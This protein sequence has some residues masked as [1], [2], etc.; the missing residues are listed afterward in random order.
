M[1]KPRSQPTRNKQRTPSQKHLRMEVLEH[2]LLLA[3]DTYLVN[4]QNDEATTPIRYERD[5]GDVFGA[6]GNGLSYGWSADHTDRAIERSADADQRLDTIISIEA[7]EDWEFALPNGNYEVTVGV[8]DPANNDGVHT[9]NVEGVSF[10][11]AEPDTSV[12]LTSTAQVTVSDGRLTLDVGAAANLATRINYIQI[13]GVPSGPNASPATPIVTEPAVDGQVVNPTDPHMEAVGFSDGDGDLHKSTDWEIWTVGPGA[14]PVW[15]T[16]GIEGVERLHTHLGDGIFLNALA[17]ET[18]LASNT[19]YEVRARFRDDAG[20]VSGYGTRLFQTGAASSV[21]PMEIE[22]IAS[23]PTP[24]WETTTGTPVEL[25]A[26][27]AI[28]SPGDAILAIDTDFGD[29]NYPFNETPQDG[30]DGNVGTKYLNFG[31]ANSGFIV[32]PSAGASVVTSFQ[33]TT[34]NDAEERDP[35]SWELYGTNDTVTSGDNSTGSAENWTL[36]DAGA[37]SLPSTRNTAGPVVDVSN[38]TSYTSYR[39]IF[40]GI[41]NAGAADS[42]QI[43]EAQFF[44]EVSGLTG[45]L[46]PGSDII[47]IDTSFGQ[48]NYPGNESP[49]NAIDGT[50]DKYLNFGEVNSGFIVTPSAAATVVESFQIT[51]ANDSEERD[52]TSWQLFGTNDPITSEDNSTGSAENWTLIDSGNV[53]LP[54]ARN[55]LGPVVPVNN[56]TAYQSYRM[57]FTGVKNAAAANSMQIAEIEFFGDN[58]LPPSSPSLRIESETGELLLA[59]DGDEAAGN[60]LTNPP[61]LSSHVDVRVVIT[62]GSGGLGLGNTD[63]TFTDD[64]GQERTIFLPEISLGAGETAYFWVSLDGSTYVGQAGQT[65]ADF[66]F[67]ARPAN[68]DVPFIAMQP[69]YVVEEVSSDYRLPVNIAFVP[70]PGPNPDDPLYYITELYGSIQ[71]VTRDGTKHEFATGL[72][73]YNPQGPISGSGEQGLTGIAVQRDE[74]NLDIYHL[75]VGMLWDN[76]SPP[77]GASHY[78]KVERLDSVAGGLSL[79]TRTVLLN[80]QPETQGQSH[81]ISNITIGPD[82]KLYVHNGDGFDAST[83]LDL[84]QY[85]GKILRMNLDGT[86]PTDN[87]FYDAG[88]GIN[89]RDYIYAYGVRNPFGGAWRASDGKHYAVENGPSVDRM[90]QIN[91][92]VN[93]GWNGSN[94]SMFI[95]AIYNWNPSHAPVNI[96]FVQPETFDGSLFPAEMQDMAFVSESGP[97]YAQGAQAQGKR[98]VGFELDANGDVVGGPTTLV[99]YVGLGRS[100]VVGLAAG[101]DGLYFT[102]LYEESGA[103]GPTASGARVFRVRYVGGTTGDFDI[104]GDVD[105]ADLTRWQ[106]GYGTTT[107]ATVANGDTD[108]DNDVDGS[109]FLAWQRNYTGTPVPSA[110]SAVAAVAT[111]SAPVST[112]S[113]P[114]ET[115]RSVVASTASSSVIEGLGWISVPDATISANE[116]TSETTDQRSNEYVARRARYQA[117]DNYEGQVRGSKAVEIVA[118]QQRFRSDTDSSTLDSPVGS[119]SLDEAFDRWFAG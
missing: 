82:G 1:S 52:P 111:Q 96:T 70:D 30:I 35:T 25:P 86:A 80:M 81:Q 58:G 17:G 45:L 65:E 72:L 115:E 93:Y 51:T 23:S 92:G 99:E 74:N 21:F 42:M 11:N 101:P 4:F 20:A 8:G 63:I 33:I 89:S 10:W 40:T 15:Q 61:E 50:L 29:S 7:G 114:A 102:E 16:L 112:A 59:I 55:T 95:N 37:I 108:Q 87:P 110:A 60:S 14:Q 73:D 68:L 119:P 83:A 66:S 36:I 32:T 31:K 117:F 3:G 24:T 67:L 19:N 79:D 56:S 84:D 97:T 88:N 98:I 85:R 118:L 53:S 78:P 71:V 38:A 76:G 9:L 27:P 69:G 100:S 12:A 22:D 44:G 18:S 39:M 90:A 13:V 75:Y 28:L 34:A 47:A 46:T 41:K 26:A 116:T 103:S 57:L 104:D 48:S 62:G 5:L 106:N 49:Q 109:D 107:I 64:E 105:G 91:E 77:G 6:R 94:A 54:S 2:R 43:A 113:S